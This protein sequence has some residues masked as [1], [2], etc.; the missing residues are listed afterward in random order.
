MEILL[1]KK[2]FNK[3]GIILSE[4]NTNNDNEIILQEKNNSKFIKYLEKYGINGVGNGYVDGIWD[5]NNLENIIS[6]F[7]FNKKHFEIFIDENKK[8]KKRKYK[9]RI[10]INNHIEGVTSENKNYII[11]GFFN[12]KNTTTNESIKN[13]IEYYIK[14]LNIKKGMNIL[15]LQKDY[16]NIGDYIA[17]KTNSLVTILINSQSETN[18]HKP[19]NNVFKF[20]HIADFDMFSNNKYDRIISINFFESLKKK[21]YLSYFNECHK[22]LNEKG[23]MVITSMCKY[24]SNIFDMEPWF[25]SVFSEKINIPVFNDIIECSKEYF[26]ISSIE[27]YSNS[28]CNILK[29]NLEYFKSSIDTNKK[30]E[31]DYF[32]IK[33]LEFYLCTIYILFLSKIMCFCDFYLFKKNS[34]YNHIELIKYNITEK[35]NSDNSKTIKLNSYNEDIYLD[36]C[37][38]MLSQSEKNIFSNLL[39]NYGEQK[40][41]S[42]IV[43]L[44]FSKTIQSLN[45][46]IENHKNIDVEKYLDNIESMITNNIEVNDKKIDILDINVKNFRYIKK[47]YLYLD[48][49]TQTE[50]LS[51]V[52]KNIEFYSINNHKLKHIT[53]INISSDHID[54]FSL[55]GELVLNNI[56]KIITNN[57][58]ISDIYEFN[59]NNIGKLYYKYIY[60]NEITKKKIITKKQTRVFIIKSLKNVKSYIEGLQNISDE[61][62]INF[63]GSFLVILIG[64]FSKMYN[65]IMENELDIKMQDN[66][67]S[68]SINI[69]NIKVWI[70]YFLQ[71]IIN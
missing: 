14:K 38:K 40:Y 32:V 67:I 25:N 43:L 65:N 62:M 4:K 10:V 60:I 11:G 35:S 23:Y 29:K 51:V 66:I 39:R 37:E 70:K 15:C 6:K 41:T 22:K 59:A 63:L 48:I 17:K 20:K 21:D 45:Y 24:N 46:N 58:N 64:N 68:S 18:K 3:C 31:G 1:I 36:Y 2:L 53:K 27:N 26:Q 16:N 57:S 12:D 52:K 69:K 47:L 34:S 30:K 9:K 49:K 56:L 71:E 61:N 50:I 42:S 33:S 44:L 8:Y 19:N 54:T 55:S 5:C 13:R 7:L 28:Y